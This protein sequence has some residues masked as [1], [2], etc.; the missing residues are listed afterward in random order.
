[1]LQNWAPHF[2]HP[3]TY[4]SRAYL[5]KPWSIYC[6]HIAMSDA[7]VTTISLIQVSESTIILL[8]PT[9]SPFIGIGTEILPTIS[10]PPNSPPDPFWQ[11][12]PTTQTSSTAVTDSTATYS[13]TPSPSAD[14]PTPT[15]ARSPQR[16]SGST[17]AL[18]V[19]LFGGVPP[20]CGT[21]ISALE[22]A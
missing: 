17:A 1:M 22:A 19:G 14:A 3:R 16:H 4:S 15:T 8:P 11:T 5:I 9:F 13:P 21:C 12:N 20:S 10:S 7:I 6:G 18:V 2:L